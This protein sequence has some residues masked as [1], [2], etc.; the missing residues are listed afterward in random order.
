MENSAIRINFS[1]SALTGIPKGTIVEYKLALPEE[2]ASTAYNHI[3]I[4]WNPQGQEPREFVTC[5]I[6]MSTFK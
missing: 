3:E 6:L 5:S 1:E 2:A 4:D